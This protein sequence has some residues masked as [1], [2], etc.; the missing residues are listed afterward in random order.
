MK[1]SSVADNLNSLLFT[2][3]THFVSSIF[4]RFTTVNLSGAELATATARCQNIQGCGKVTRYTKYRIV[5]TLGP[6]KTIKVSS[7]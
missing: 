7:P 6:S 1:F 4:T 3:I 5:D 2:L